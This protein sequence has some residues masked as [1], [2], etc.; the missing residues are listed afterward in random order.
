MFLIGHPFTAPAVNPDMN[1]LLAKKYIIRTGRIAI[2]APAS[3]I[4]HSAAEFMEY[5]SCTTATVKV[6][7][8]GMEILITNVV[9]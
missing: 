6:F 7:S 3:M 5:L 4:C 8:A 1:C 2:E 9:T